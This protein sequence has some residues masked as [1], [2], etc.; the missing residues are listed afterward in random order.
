V[1]AVYIDEKKKVLLVMGMEHKLD[2]IMK[3]FPTINQKNMIVLQSYEAVISPFSDVMRDIIVAVY[4]E[5]VEEIFVAA[6]KMDS[7]NTGNFLNKIYENKELQEK[8]QTL[9]YLFKNCKPEFPEESL[10]E[11]LSGGKNVTDDIQNR[12]NVI[13]HHP[14]MPSNVKIT[15]LWMDT[16]NEKILENF[17]F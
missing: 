2:C 3:Q 7:K 11:W 16:E 4:Q 5:N 12:A 17:V 15:E 8:I 9:D 10:Y 6:T 14:L 13:R 1:N